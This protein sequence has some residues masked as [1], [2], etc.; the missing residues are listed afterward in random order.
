MQEEKTEFNTNYKIFRKIK[1]TKKY[2]TEMI[3]KMLKG[4][5]YSFIF[6]F[7][8]SRSIFSFR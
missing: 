8:F 7:H 6:I 5:F 3:K 2:L 4:I 1:K